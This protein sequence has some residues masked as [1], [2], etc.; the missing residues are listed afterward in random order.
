MRC[1]IVSGSRTGSSLLQHLL[2]PYLL[3]KYGYHKALGDAF[4]LRMW[5]YDS[6]WDIGKIRLTHMTEQDAR[7][8]P[9]DHGF[10]MDRR[11]DLLQK[12]HE[13]KYFVKMCPEVFL[14]CSQNRLRYIKENYRLIVIDRKNKWE[15]A[16]SHA[17]A[18]NSNFYTMRAEEDV[19]QFRPGAFTSEIGDI[20]T[21]DFLYF[22]EAKKRIM[23]IRNDFVWDLIFYEDIIASIE[24]DAGAYHA[25][26]HLGINDWHKYI[27]PG[28]TVPHRIA[29]HMNKQA[30]ITNVADF[31]KWFK[32]MESTHDAFA[33]N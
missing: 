21:D 11:V 1:C 8:L 3:R 23:D 17:I 33:S 22:H 5:L 13:Q 18:L 26:R 30:Y 7:L 20:I 27:I 29:D 32:N 25:L 28:D 12:Y 19:T 2:W 9:I 6:G 24:A 10:E 14:T 15:R 16:L 31:E 4:M